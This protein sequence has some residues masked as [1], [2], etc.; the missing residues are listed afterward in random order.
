MSATLETLRDQI[1]QIWRKLRHLEALETMEP[2][3][4]ADTVD[5]FDASAI[6]TA[7]T[8]LALDGDGALPADITGDADTVDGF[9]A[10]DVAM[11]N[12]LLALD[13][14]A[15]LPADITGDAATVGG[16]AADEIPTA[17]V[18]GVFSPLRAEFLHKDH[19]E[20]FY[21]RAISTGVRTDTVGD[22]S[23]PGCVL[24]GG[25]AGT[26]NSGYVMMTSVGAFLLAGNEE[27]E[28]VFKPTD[29]HA[30]NY[31]LLGWMDKDDATLAPL[32]VYIRVNGTTL[33]GQCKNVSGATGTG[34][35]YGYSAGTWYRA[36]IVINAAANLVTFTLY[37]AA[38]ASL[39]SQTVNANIPVA[40]GD[41]VGCGATWMQTSTTL[42]TC[43]IDWMSMRIK[44][45]L[46]R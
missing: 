1:E 27:F 37:N 35:N 39:W 15:M 22:A 10:S 45:G 16:Y 28:I 18:P 19:N 2:S 31:G 46:T 24:I 4:D 8:L 42:R 23:H 36:T 34:T 40:G 6:A 11:A 3:T 12:T 13:A 38:G 5:G 9:H 30:E 32:G 20:D 29:A 41:E 43:S 26:S 25:K 33:D 7:N 17:Y 14:N 44:R 21:G